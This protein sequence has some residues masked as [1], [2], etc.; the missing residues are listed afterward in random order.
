M[1]DLIINAPN[2]RVGGGLV[3]LKSLVNAV[4][5]LEI[6]CLLIINEKINEEIQKSIL[7]TVK[8]VK[9]SFSARIMNE[10]YLRNISKSTNKMLL[11]GNMPPLF[12]LKCETVLY[13]QNAY[14]INR[15]SLSGF[16]IKPRIR[17]II[18][19][20]WFQFFWKK[21]NKFMVQT[22]SMNKLLS[23]IVTSDI[24]ICPFIDYD[25]YKKNTISIFDFI[26]PSSGEPHKNHKNLI[27][28]WV[29]LA[30]KGLYPSLYLTL[31]ENVFK[32]L[33]L[34]IDEN[35]KKHNLNI[36]NLG[37]LH[38]RPEMLSL[39]SQAKC[40][41]FPSWL[42]SFGLPLIEAQKFNIP[43]LAPEL[44][45]VRD[46]VKPHQTFD[47]K[48]PISICSAVLRFMGKDEIN[49]ILKP[50]QFINKVISN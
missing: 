19:R 45:Y 5:K 39:I 28:A 12:S 11:F 32:K 8:Y 22:N 17:I 23:E 26:Y 1:Y 21:V 48:S 15:V 20:I 18:E 7:I 25:F 2:I 30:E 13:M 36:E 27:E 35:I 37:H 44:D 3:L 47:A 31:D 41:I 43:I 4:N 38:T 24:D 6:K 42:E 10:F 34:W 16:G 50:E 33:I 46:V 29:T 40:M 9:H 14:I 49:T